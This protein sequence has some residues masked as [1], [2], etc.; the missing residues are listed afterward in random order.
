MTSWTSSLLSLAS[1]LAL[2]A[3][4]GHGLELMSG[5]GRLSAGSEELPPFFDYDCVLVGSSKKEKAAVAPWNQLFDWVELNTIMQPV[6][7]DRNYTLL[8]EMLHLVDEGPEQEQ[9][10]EECPVGAL[11]LLVVHYH[12]EGLQ[13]PMAEK[14]RMLQRLHRFFKILPV[15]AIAGSRWPVFLALEFFSTMHSGLP[16]ED[17]DCQS[18]DGHSQVTNWTQLYNEVKFWVHTTHRDDLDS[19]DALLS[20]LSGETMPSLQQ[21]CHTVLR[22]VQAHSQAIRECPM[23]MAFIALVQLVITAGKRTQN[24]PSFSDTVNLLL[25]SVSI[26]WIARSGWPIFTLLAVFEDRTKGYYYFKGD[27]KYNRN[28]GDWD[29]RS[30]ELS[31]VAFAGNFAFMSAPWKAAVSAE[32]TRLAALPRSDFI[33]ALK[34]HDAMRMQ[35]HGVRKVVVGLF[36]A[37][38]QL[39]RL[40]P[41]GRRFAY[42]VLLYGEDWAAVLSQLSVQ[43][44]LFVVAIGEA[45]YGTCTE[46]QM[47]SKPVVCWRPESESQVHRFTAVNALLHVG[48]DVLYLDMDTLLVRDPAEY[49]LKQAEGLDALFARHADADCVNIGVFFIRASDRTALWMSQFM[50]WYHDNCF[51]IDQR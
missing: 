18:Q 13:R 22:S 48:I 37:I 5:R 23:G 7:A 41:L 34:D 6:V 10:E 30:D 42:V 35:E 15:Y 31:P 29:M 26:E 39:A 4:T 36:E 45:A 9:A 46:L 51:E 50:A 49:I 1:L 20:T 16:V 11:Y 3:G 25:G 19:G 17:L 28:Y 32:A 47:S 38:A 27:R 33:E 44:V 43:H 24:L 8:P 2:N 12:Q 21:H 14:H 40:A